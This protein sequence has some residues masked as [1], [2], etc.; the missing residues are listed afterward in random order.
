MEAD[1]DY[2]RKRNATA[3]LALPLQLS[4]LSETEQNMGLKLSH[5]C[6]VWVIMFTIIFISYFEQMKAVRV[7]CFKSGQNRRWL[8]PTNGMI[9]VISMILLVCT[10]KIYT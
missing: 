5:L 1:F 8:E 9:S 2:H 6:P 4:V 10:Y 3:I 7:A